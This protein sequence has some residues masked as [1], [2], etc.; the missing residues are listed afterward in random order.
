[1]YGFGVDGLNA[2]KQQAWDEH[3]PSKETEKAAINLLK[4]ITIGID[5]EKEKTI[6]KMLYF[7]KDLINKFNGIMNYNLNSLEDIPNINASIKRNVNTVLQP[8]ILQPNIVINTQKLDNAEMNRIIDTVNRR[9][10][11]Q[12]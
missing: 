4:G 1:M 5:K 2:I 10:G 9:F 6:N 3:S 8:K 12:I 7:G 11:M